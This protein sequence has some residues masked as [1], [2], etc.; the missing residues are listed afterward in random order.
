MA[1]KLKMRLE[2]IYCER[3]QSVEKKDDFVEMISHRK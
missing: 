1:L 2:M 3:S